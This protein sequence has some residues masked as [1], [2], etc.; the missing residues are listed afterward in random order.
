MKI[1]QVKLNMAAIQMKTTLILN[2]VK[3][4]KDSS[5]LIAKI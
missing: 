1:M 2:Y 3:Q 5:L 4:F